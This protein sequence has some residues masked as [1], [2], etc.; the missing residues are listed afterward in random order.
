M[1][2]DLKFLDIQRQDP[3][4][5]IQDL[6]P[7]RQTLRVEPYL[8]MQSVFLIAVV[9]RNTD[10][11]LCHTAGRDVPTAKS[12]EEDPWRADRRDLPDLLLH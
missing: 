6:T 7:Y 5:L 10:H 11:L 3:L 1:L 9:D 12:L 2:Q 4:S 8:Q